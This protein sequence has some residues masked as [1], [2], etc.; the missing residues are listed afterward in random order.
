MYMIKQIKEEIV[1]YYR[2]NW[3]IE[4]YIIFDILTI[5]ISSGYQ[6]LTA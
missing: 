4:Y 1:L 2:N 3:D 5:L 6:W